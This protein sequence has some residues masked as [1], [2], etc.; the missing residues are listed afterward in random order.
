MTSIEETHHI[1]KQFFIDEWNDE[2][3]IIHCGSVL[4]ACI[5]FI[6]DTNIDQVPFILS[7]WVHDLGKLIDKEMHHEKSIVYW[8]KFLEKYPEY[9]EQ[10]ELVRE[11]ILTH[12]TGGEPKSLHAKIF[13]I[14]DKVALYNDEFLEFKR[15]QKAL[16]EQ[17]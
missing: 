10:D 2:K 8:E 11:C 9:T 3:H 7:A 14:A 5:G 6:Q 1:A 16:K 4:H 12:R 15:K 13:Q 17:A